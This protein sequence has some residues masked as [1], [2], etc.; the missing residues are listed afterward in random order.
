M[1]Y[2]KTNTKIKHKINKKG[3]EILKNKEA[4]QRLDINEESN[5]FFTLKDHKENFQNNPTARLINPA[6]IEIGGI[7]QARFRQNKLKSTKQLKA[8]QWKN[9][10]NVIEWFMKIEEKSKYKLIVFDIKDF[11]PSLKETLLIKAINL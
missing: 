3:T 6:R 10:L 9:T 2:K 8:N 5:C 11:Y 7:S 4:L 1:K